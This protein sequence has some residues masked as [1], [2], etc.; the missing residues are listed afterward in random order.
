MSKLAVFICAFLG[1]H[2]VIPMMFPALNQVAF[3]LATLEITWRW[4]V[5]LSVCYLAFKM[6]AD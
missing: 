5:T 2:F 6:N 3:S 4:I 1:A